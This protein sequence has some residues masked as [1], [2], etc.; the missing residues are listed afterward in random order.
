M[1][2]VSPRLA[3][4]GRTVL[5]HGCPELVAA[6]DAGLVA[7]STASE[8]AALPQEEQ[9][10]AVAG[11]VKEIARVVRERRESRAAAPGVQQ[12]PGRRFGLVGVDRTVHVVAG[13]DR[14][15]L[16]WVAASG[17][18]AAIERLKTGGFRYAPE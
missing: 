2:N 7:A 6:V 5:S 14:V 16:L 18:S 1:V 13:E 3:G 10:K 8:L 9:A 17:I 12:Q 15:A 4:H 11:G